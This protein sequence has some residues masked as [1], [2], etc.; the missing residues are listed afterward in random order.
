MPISSLACPCHEPSIPSHTSAKSLS[1]AWLLDSEQGCGPDRVSGVRSSNRWGSPWACEEPCRIWSCVLDRVRRV[2]QDLILACGARWRWHGTMIPVNRDSMGPWGCVG[3]ILAHRVQSSPWIYPAPFTWS[4][5]PKHW[6]PLTLSQCMFPSRKTRA[7]Q[8]RQQPWA[9]T[10]GRAWKN[11]SCCYSCVTKPVTLAVGS[12]HCPL[13]SLLPLAP[14]CPVMP[15]MFRICCPPRPLFFVE[16]SCCLLRK[17]TGL[18]SVELEHCFD[19]QSSLGHISPAV[20]ICYFHLKRS[21]G[22]SK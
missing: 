1:R 10:L 15:L 6:A 19:L 9:L 12:H 18:S 20:E 13:A 4:A 17:G 11:N 5:R 3:W 16:Q 2:G 8:P 21:Q 14:R 7:G 22:V